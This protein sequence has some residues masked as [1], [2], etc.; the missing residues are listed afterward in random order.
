VFVNVTGLQ[1]NPVVTP[2]TVIVHDVQS[3]CVQSLLRLLG[4]LQADLKADEALL[5]AENHEVAGLPVS[6][7]PD[8]KLV[9]LEFKGG[10]MLLGDGEQLVCHSHCLFRTS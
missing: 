6:S 10:V 1:T 2:A 5:G 3:S 4:V 9:V 7:K 8:L